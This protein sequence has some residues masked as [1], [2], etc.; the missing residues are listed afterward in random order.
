MALR[1]K[2]PKEEVIEVLGEKVKIVPPDY[3]KYLSMQEWISERSPG[4]KATKKQQT[5]FG[6][7]YSA[8]CIQVACPEEKLS[9]K[10]SVEILIA[11][12]GSMGVLA[13]KAMSLCGTPTEVGTA[14]NLPTS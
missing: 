8:K 1:D 11:S 5:E 14:E 7:L 3:E 2:I 6:A 12:G 4:Q 10:E 13:K 9:D